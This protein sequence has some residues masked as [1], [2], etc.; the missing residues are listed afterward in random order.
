[1]NI[2][3][4]NELLDPPPPQVTTLI[5]SS[6]PVTIDYSLTER[7]RVS[8]NVKLA[9]CTYNFTFDP[10]VEATLTD[11]AGGK[12]IDQYSVGS[13]RSGERRL[14]FGPSHGGPGPSLSGTA[15]FPGH[16]NVWGTLNSGEAFFAGLDGVILGGLM[17]E[18]NAG[19]ASVNWSFERSN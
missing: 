18:D 7:S 14:E 11:S 17:G 16:S 19:S 4:R 2:N 6:A 5:G 3:D 8:L 13:L 15:N 10:I 12:S 1:M 9:T